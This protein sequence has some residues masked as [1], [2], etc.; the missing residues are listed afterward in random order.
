MTLFEPSSRFSLFVEHDLCRKPV[1]TFR[2]HALAALG[3]ISAARVE[4]GRADLSTVPD[5]SGDPAV[6][7]DLFSHP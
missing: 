3:A 2:D 7:Q 1:S 4:R 6:W 5:A